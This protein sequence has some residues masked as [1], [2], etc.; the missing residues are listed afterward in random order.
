[1][2]TRMCWK[3]FRTS[4]ESLAALGAEGGVGGGWSKTAELSLMR[5][6]DWEKTQ[7][8]KPLLGL[9]SLKRETKIRALV[10]VNRPVWP[11]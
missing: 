10:Q 5:L 3:A 8:Q 4:P 6:W 2:S 7:D 9:L 1:M 11:P